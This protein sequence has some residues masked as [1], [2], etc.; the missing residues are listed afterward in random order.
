MVW[1]IQKHSNIR[2]TFLRASQYT[3]KTIYREKLRHEKISVP[4]AFSGYPNQLYSAYFVHRCP[5][6]N[7]KYSTVLEPVVNALQAKSVDLVKVGEHING[8]I[9]IYSKKTLKTQTKSLTNYFK[10]H[11]TL[12]WNRKY[13]FL[14]HGLLTSKYT[15]AIR[16]QTVIMTTGGVH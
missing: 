1:E 13:K 3:G 11:K 16:H 14:F 2:T 12:Q 8:I 5:N 6:Y 9:D 15:G 7:I 10:K 4:S